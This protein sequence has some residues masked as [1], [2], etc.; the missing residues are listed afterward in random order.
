MSVVMLA[1]HTEIPDSTYYDDLNSL[2]G[3]NR[4]ELGHLD[5]LNSQHTDMNSQLDIA[6][7]YFFNDCFFA[8]QQASVLAAHEPPDDKKWSDYL[9]NQSIELAD[10]DYDTKYSGSELSTISK[11]ENPELADNPSPPTNKFDKAIFWIKDTYHTWVSKDHSGTT[12]LLLLSFG[13]VGILGI[14]RKL[15]KP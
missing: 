11:D 15:K 13:L 14:R 12:R 2:Y 4:P 6:G 3:W 7:D 5:C 8:L 10:T 1:A 9:D